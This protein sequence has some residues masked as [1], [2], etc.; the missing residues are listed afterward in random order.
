MFDISIVQNLETNDSNNC[1]MVSM[2]QSIN[3]VNSED[4][5]YVSFFCKLKSLGSQ[6][7]YNL[8]GSIFMRFM[9]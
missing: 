3:M 2:A 5:L 9:F 7:L 8:C 4:A 1:D 6:V